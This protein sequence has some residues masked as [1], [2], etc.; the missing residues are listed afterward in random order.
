MSERQNANRSADKR[1]RKK[2]MLCKLQRPPVK[3]PPV[4]FVVR[5]VRLVPGTRRLNDAAGHQQS[6][7]SSTPDQP[8]HCEPTKRKYN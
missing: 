6:S 4:K 7:H 5:Y 8:D 3:F 1:A 2:E